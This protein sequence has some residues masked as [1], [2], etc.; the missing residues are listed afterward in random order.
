MA[1]RLRCG[2]GPQMTGRIVATRLSPLSARASTA[3]GLQADVRRRYLDLLKLT[4][5]RLATEDQSLNPERL[6]R[7]HR[8]QRRPTTAKARAA[9]IPGAAR[10]GPR[11]V[12]AR[13]DDGRPAPTRNL[14]DTIATLIRDDVPGDLIETGT[15]RGAPPSS[16]ARSWSRMATTPHGVGRRLVR[17][18]A[19][20][21][22][23]PLPP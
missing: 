23:Q 3:Q 18:L 10:A 11:L 8:L 7:R 19:R 14:E 1:F 4:L 22:R 17:W 9:A 21:Q 20:T 5:T 12:I 15:W 2:V 13:R 6:S 16:C